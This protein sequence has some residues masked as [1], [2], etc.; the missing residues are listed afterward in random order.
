MSC[1]CEQEQAGKP[2]PKSRE[3][4]LSPNLTLAGFYSSEQTSF[5]TVSSKTIPRKKALQRLHTVHVNK[6]T[7]YWST[8]RCLPA[9]R[10]SE[11]RFFPTWFKLISRDLL[12]YPGT[13]A[14]KPEQNRIR[15]YLFSGTVHLFSSTVNRR[16]WGRTCLSNP[17]YSSPKGLYKLLQSMRPVL[18]K[19][20]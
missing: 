3:D 5:A 1:A 9:H 8:I 19:C 17:W 4:N 12:C 6:S 16:T 7:F 18:A 20:K 10:D 2:T 15:T 14:S 13:K 11:S